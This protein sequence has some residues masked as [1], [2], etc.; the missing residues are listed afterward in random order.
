MTR[1]VEKLARQMALVEESQKGSN[2]APQLSNSSIEN[3]AI[4]EN[5][6]DGNPV[7]VFGKQYDGTHTAVSLAGPKPPQTVSAEAI[8]FPGGAE[9]RWNGKFIND[10]VSPLDLKH[11]AGYIVPQGEIPVLS[12]QSGVMTGELGDLISVQVPEPGMYDVYLAAWT[13][14]GK[15]SDLSEVVTIEVPALVDLDGV[16]DALNEMQD[17][18]DQAALDSAAA[19]TAAG[20]AATKADT[21]KSAADAATSAAAS[22]AG[23]ANGKGKVLVQPTAPG[24]ADRNT[25][26]LWID[27]TGGAN[28]PKRWTTGTTWVAVTDKVATDAAAKAATAVSDAAA[29]KARA[30]AAFT[31]AGDAMTKAGEAQASAN[32]KNNVYYRDVLPSGSGFVTGD[33]VFIRSAVGQPIT[34]QHQWDGSAWKPVTMGHQVIASVD[35]GKATV[36]ELDGIYIKANTIRAAS[37]MVGDFTNLATIDP[38][39]GVNVSIPPQWATVTDG[40]YTKS[41]PGP[42][43][44]LMFKDQT[45]TVPFVA[46]DQLRVSFDA[47]ADAATSVTPRMWVYSNKTSVGGGNIASYSGASQSITTI[48]TNFSFVLT[49]GAMPNTVVSWTM[50]LLGNAGIK[51]VKVRNISVYRMNRGTMIVDGAFDARTITAPLIQTV[52]APNRGIKWLSDALVAFNGAG[53]ETFRLSATTG[54]ASFLGKIR[55]GSTIEGAT[56]SGGSISIGSAKTSYVNIDVYGSSAAIEFKDKSVYS[57][58]MINTTPFYSLTLGSPQETSSKYSSLSLGGAKSGSVAALSADSIELDSKKISLGGGIFTA[59]DIVA[60]AD[61]MSPKLTFTNSTSGK[62]YFY[63]GEVMLAGSDNTSGWVAR[64]AV[65]GGGDNQSVGIKTSASGS[66]FNAPPIYSLTGTA[67]ASLYVSSAGWVYRSTSVR[68]N[69]L[70]IQEVDSSVEDKLLSLKAYTWFDKRESEEWAAYVEAAEKGEELPDLMEPGKLRRIGGMIADEVADAGLDEIVT[71]DSD[72]NYEGIMYER[73]GAYLIPVVGRLKK[74]VIGLEQR[75][76]ELENRVA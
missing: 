12:R 43:N 42:E 45:D 40:L 67:A 21:A 7:G 11:V 50:G 26:T 25:V 37:V 59:A 8:P 63:S 36:G 39:R 3:G 4:R 16:G 27:T 65:R 35:L 69:K 49:V 55:S 15:V 33:T 22:A 71:R 72:G 2:L 13:L 41:G 64:M 18:V 57:S 48:E 38:V 28:T 6:E 74:R 76:E 9:I 70:D 1:N 10:I 29:A 24:A 30:D 66:W 44:Y 73:L 68:A 51:G 31:A 54:E 60:D 53:T 46:G 62:M 19:N 20:E 17:K 61:I 34:A 23:I 56:I 32:G 58:A 47:V 75:I 5:D 14:S 52:V